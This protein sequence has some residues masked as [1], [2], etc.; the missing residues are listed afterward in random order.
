[1]SAYILSYDFSTASNLHTQLV[2]FVKS[3]RNVTQWSHPFVGCFILKSEA[4]LPALVESFG[5]FFGGRTLHVVAPLIGQQTGGIL[6]LYLWDW[7]N[8]PQISAL[9]G[10][11]GNY[12]ENVPPRK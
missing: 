1:M 2:A 4:G 11:L 12:L 8:E 10:L 9:S 6:P 5:E 3:N 7:L